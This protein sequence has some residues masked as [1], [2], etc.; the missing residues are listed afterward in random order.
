M[1]G[2]IMET[3]PFVDAGMWELKYQ[4]LLLRFEQE[5]AKVGQLYE[6][7]ASRDVIGQAKGVL[8]ERHRL[9]AD[10]AFQLL[11]LASSRTNLKLHEV[12]RKLVTTGVLVAP[13]P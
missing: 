7:L 3:Y 1:R 9:D 2:S 5:R 13:E 8:M 4:E 11:M 10:G 6:A 12:A